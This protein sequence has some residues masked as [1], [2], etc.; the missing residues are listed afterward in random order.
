MGDLNIILDEQKAKPPP[1]LRSLKSRGVACGSWALSWVAGRG[2]S[3]SPTNAITCSWTF[4]LLRGKELHV[5]AADQFRILNSED[6]AKPSFCTIRAYFCEVCRSW[7]RAQR[8]TVPP[9]QQTRIRVWQAGRRRLAVVPSCRPHTLGVQV[10]VRRAGRAALTADAQSAVRRS[11]SPHAIRARDDAHVE[12]GAHAKRRVI[13]L[14]LV[15]K[16]ML[17][18]RVAPRT[19]DC[20]WRGLGRVEVFEVEY[21]H[22]CTYSRKREL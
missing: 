11:R 12:G 8:V 22:A 1:S 3:T 10:A 14:G 16:L 19:R 2:A 9:S 13:M 5:A 15:W 4:Y 20:H 21:C 18:R 7:Y 17:Q 6:L